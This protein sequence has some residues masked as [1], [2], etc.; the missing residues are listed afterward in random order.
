[1][2]LAG[3]IS[4]AQSVNNRLDKFEATYQRSKQLVNSQRIY[5]N[6]N[7]VYG[8]GKRVRLDTI[9]NTLI[10]TKKS[11]RG[12]LQTSLG[13]TSMINLDGAVE[14]YNIRFDDIKKHIEILFDLMTKE[15]SEKITIGIKPNG[16]V[17]LIT[18]LKNAKGMT[19]LGN[20]TN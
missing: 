16:M 9:S 13:E 18:T 8:N 12:N 4:E 10:V 6:F 19:W 17:N 3:S 5:I 1:M 14:N 2:L 11:S 15:G 7:L 20:L